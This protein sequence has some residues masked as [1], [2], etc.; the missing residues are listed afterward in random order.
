MDLLDLKLEDIK[1]LYKKKGYPFYER[2]NFNL[3]F[4]GIR[5]ND[6]DSH[7]TGQW[8]DV[9]GITYKHPSKGW[10]LFLYP[11]S[12]D[13]GTYYSE[14]PLNSKG[15]AFLVEGHYRGLYSRGI[16]NRKYEALRQVSNVKVYRD[17]TKD[18]IIDLD[19]STIEEGIFYTN[20]HC[21]FERKSNYKSSAGCQ[22][23]KARYSDDEYW[24]FLWHFDKS[25]EIWGNKFSYSLFNAKDLEE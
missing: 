2:G 25:A 23:T 6:H 7:I 10:L 13:A 8:D 11:A 18:N 16:H 4:F 19:P 3:N 20:V 22:I 17:N 14:R 21:S 1:K 24:Q 5:Q 9:L 15:T 12:V